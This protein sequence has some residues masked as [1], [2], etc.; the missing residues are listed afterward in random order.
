[1]VFGK[2]MH[3]LLH[4]F[5]SGRAGLWHM[6]FFAQA[7]VLARRGMMVR[8]QVQAL[9][10]RQAGDKRRGL[11]QVFFVIGDAG[12]DRHA[13]D[14]AVTALDSIRA[15]TDLFLYDLKLMDDTRHRL[16]TGV[17]NGLILHNLEALSRSGARII[18]RVPV[19]P[20]ITDDEENLR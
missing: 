14:D 20:G 19:I 1:M 9:D 16:Y 7:L 12:D 10:V 17:P 5:V 18:V 6:I 2:E 15:D 11:A 3:D 4:P 13:H 8:Q